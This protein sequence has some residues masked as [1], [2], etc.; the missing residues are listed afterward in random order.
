MGCGE[1]ALGLMH[2][3]QVFND[4]TIVLALMPIFQMETLRFPP[5]CPSKPTKKQQSPNPLS[6]LCEITKVQLAPNVLW[7]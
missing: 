2:A 5:S 3:K 1:E 4:R 7:N 6:P